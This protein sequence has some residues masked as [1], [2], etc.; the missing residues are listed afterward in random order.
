[1][2]SG[3]SPTISTPDRSRITGNHAALFRKLWP[4]W[5]QVGI[6]PSYD[7]S[8]LVA[9]RCLWLGC[10]G[11]IEH[12]ATI[13]TLALWICFATQVGPHP[14]HC[15]KDC[16][17]SLSSPRSLN[18]ALH[19]T[20]WNR[21]ARHTCSHRRGCICRVPGCGSHPEQ[22]CPAQQKVPAGN[23]TQTTEGLPPRS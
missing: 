15:L 23:N 17:F 5:S 12:A 2:S 10:H 22:L 4:I 18:T 21:H 8:D 14:V 11:L 3:T 7:L 13:C 6:L 20:L 9:R 16:H 1:M 19:V